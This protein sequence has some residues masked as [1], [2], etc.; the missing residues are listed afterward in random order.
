MLSTIKTGFLEGPNGK[1]HVSI[2]V[3][4]Q[5]VPLRGCVIHVPAFAE[6]MNKCR[7]MVSRQ[8]RGLAESG[9]AVVVPDL[10][11]T[12][13]SEGEFSSATWLNWKA[14]LAYLVHW[15]Q[16]RVGGRGCPVGSAARGSAGPGCHG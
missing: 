16:D 1:L 8:A 9:I 3:P 7:P 15:S 13:D 2:F 12:G 14:D 10:S 4:S 5:A 11:G 6:E